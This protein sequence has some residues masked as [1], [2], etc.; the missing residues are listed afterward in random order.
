MRRVVIAAAVTAAVIASVVG[1]AAAGA[2]AGEGAPKAR[3]MLVISLPTVSWQDVNDHDLPN[4]NRFLD[5]AAVADL[6][7][8]SVKRDS[9]LGDGYITLG[10][11]T[12]SL[13]NSSDTSSDG[14]ALEV[15]E[16]FGADSAVRGAHRGAGSSTWTSPT[17]S[18]ATRR[19]CTTPRSGRS[20]TRSAARA[21]RAP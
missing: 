12:R 17:S 15:G 16:P 8:R 4:L 13:G 2:G 5:D 10:A 11:G 18:S 6:T 19:S 1:S 21:G 20:A 3:R 9:R 14:E 7:N